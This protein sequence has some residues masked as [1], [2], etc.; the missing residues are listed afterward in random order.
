MG[1]GK[2]CDNRY[3]MSIAKVRAFNVIQPALNVVKTSLPKGTVKAKARR[4]GPAKT[5]RRSCSEQGE[6]LAHRE[7]LTVGSPKK[8][9]KRPRLNA[10]EEVRKGKE[11]VL[12]RKG[13]LDGWISIKEVQRSRSIVNR[14]VCKDLQRGGPDGQMYKEEVWTVKIS[15]GEVLTSRSS[16][17]EVWTVKISKGGDLNVQIYKEEVWTVKISKG[18]VLTVQIYKEE[19][20]TVKISKGEV[21]TVQ[22][23]KEEDQTVQCK[24]DDS[25]SIEMQIGKEEVLEDPGRFGRTRGGPIKVRGGP[26]GHGE[27]LKDAERSNKGKGRSEEAV[28][29]HGAGGTTGLVLKGTSREGFKATNGEGKSKENQTI[30][31]AMRMRVAYY[32][33]E[34][35]EYCSNEERSLYHDLNAYRVFFD[36]VYPSYGSPKM[37]QKKFFSDNLDCSEALFHPRQRTLS[38][39][40]SYLEKLTPKVATPVKHGLKDIMVANKMKEQKTQTPKLKTFEGPHA[41]CRLDSLKDIFLW[42]DVLGSMLGSEDLPKALPRLVGSTKML[43]VQSIACGENH[44]AIITKQG[45]VFSWGKESSGRLG[46]KVNVSLSCPKI[47]KTL[48]SVHV[49]VVAFGSKHTCAVTVSGELFEWGEGANSLGLLN[50]W[51]GRNQWV[52]HKL[53]GPMDNISVSKIACGEWHMAIITSSGQLFTYGDGTFGVLGHGDTQGIARPKE[54]ESLKGLRMSSVACGPWHTAAIVEVMSSFKANAPSG[55]LFTWGNADRG[56]LDHADKKMKLVPTCVDSLIVYDFIQ[57]S[58]GMALTVVLTVTGVVFTV[59]SSRHGQLGNPQ[60]DGEY[61]CTVEGLLK[62][63]F[64]REISSGSSHVAVLTMNGKV[65]TWGKGAEGQLGLGDYVNRSSPTLVEALEGRHVESIACGSSFTAAICLH[66]A[67]SIKDQ[68]V[69]SGCQMAFGFTRKKHNCYNCGSMFCNSCSSNKIAKAS[70]APENRRYRVCDVCFCQLQK[71]VDSSKVKSELKTSKGEMFKTE[72]KSYTPKLSRIFKEANFIVEKMA[73]LQGPN[74]RNED[75]ATPVQVKTQRWG[76]VEC[77]AQFISAQDSFQNKPMSKNQMCGISFSQRMHDSVVLRS[78]SSLQQSADELKEYDILVD[79]QAVVRDEAAKCKPAKDVIKVLTDQR[80]SLDILVSEPTI[81]PSTM[82]SSGGNEDF[83]QGQPSSEDGGEE[84][85]TV[86]RPGAD[87]ELPPSQ[88]RSNEGSGVAPMALPP[89][90]PPP[91]LPAPGTGHQRNP[92]RCVKLNFLTF[93]YKEDPLPWI[94]RCEP[95]FRAQKTPMDD[96]VWLV[97]YHMSGGSVAHLW[98]MRVE[99][100]DGMP[101]WRHFTDLVPRRFGAPTRHNPLGALTSIRRTTSVELD[102]EDDEEV[103]EDATISLLALTGIRKAQT[104][105]PPVLINGIQL[106]ALVDSGSTHNFIAAELIDKVGLKLAPRTGLSVAVANGNKITCGGVCY[107]TPISI[108]HEHFVLDLL[109][110]PLGGFDIV[111]GVQWLRSLGPITWDFSN[112]TMR[113]HRQD[114]TVTWHGVAPVQPARHLHAAAAVGELMEE[115]LAEFPS[116]F[117]EP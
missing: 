32:I 89:R 99:R 9:S 115:L 51:Y 100:M 107:T 63:E 85:K 59:G 47:V 69:C 12:T 33:A 77:P 79:V 65:F 21:L 76:Q 98:Y 101:N 7:V 52:P 10:P 15:K 31:W 24:S 22:I 30:E 35:L 62:T 102:E 53:F 41:A 117:D 73:L 80:S 86:A 103:D 83:Q 106:M 78:G 26:R 18:K 88:H 111:L 27:V 19:V 11:E 49:K 40:D 82:L 8:R 28:V 5:M 105:Q 87:G 109:T 43:D 16:R 75:S 13:G 114:R 36:E 113:L 71:A 1:V 116:V 4:G 70:F 6:I 20:W 25:R 14:E 50:D 55:K 84:G 38:D 3:D 74:Q 56:K 2:E 81:A 94:N 61:I 23:Y 66:K 64:V 57:V 29:P 46:H 92:P 67:I 96:R 54:V 91:H 112:L 42:G 45:E 37:T 17:R 95:F 34:A 58:C 72:M 44:A 60:V 90:L 48:A 39:I 97:T 93:D 108:D 68:S 104:M 110:I